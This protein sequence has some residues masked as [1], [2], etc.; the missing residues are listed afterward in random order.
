MFVSLVRTTNCL[1]GSAGIVNSI[2]HDALINIILR[3]E[4]AS[5]FCVTECEHR[6]PQLWAAC[7]T[8]CKRLHVMECIQY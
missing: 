5:K 7:L 2:D 6:G 4:A 1:V 8:S 3:E